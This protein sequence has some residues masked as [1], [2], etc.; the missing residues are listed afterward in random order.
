M[1]TRIALLGLGLLTL[2][3]VTGLPHRRTGSDITLRDSPA[4]QAIQGLA[5]S[6][7]PDSNSPSATAGGKNV[8]D[9]GGVNTDTVAVNDPQRTSTSPKTP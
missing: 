8:V 7:D 1:Q 4:R 6:C 9:C 2:G 5:R 3:C